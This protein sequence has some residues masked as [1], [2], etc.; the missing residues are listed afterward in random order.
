MKFGQ[1]SE[2]KRQLRRSRYRWKGDVI[3]DI[4]ECGLEVVDFI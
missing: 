1:K 3:M 4:T 2:W